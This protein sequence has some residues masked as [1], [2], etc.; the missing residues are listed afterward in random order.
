M[1]FFTF[2]IAA[3][4][5]GILVSISPCP[6]ATNIVAISYLSQQINQKIKIMLQSLAYIAGRTVIYVILA[7]LIVNAMM[8]IPVIS[9]FLQTYI[10]RLLG[11]FL[12]ITGM[13]LLKLIEIKL[14]GITISERMQKKFQSSGYIKATLL[15]MIFALAFCP[16]SAA[17]YF[18]SLIPMALKIKSA[19]LLPIAFGIFSGLPVALFAIIIA[20]S[21]HKIGSYFASLSRIEYY[22]TKITGVI[23]ILAGIYYVLSY[24]FGINLTFGGSL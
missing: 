2:I 10:T 13:V 19:F 24:I 11:I 14:P 4:W 23:F 20:F 3:A 15:G 7:Y 18:G 1:E 5:L 16:I 17:I 12:I 6:L 22:V 21:A 8:N 9:E